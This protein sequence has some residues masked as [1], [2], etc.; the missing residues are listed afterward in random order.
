[1]NEFYARRGEKRAG[2]AAKQRGDVAM[3]QIGETGGA[4]RLFEGWESA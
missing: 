1:M 2:A 3:K 4:A